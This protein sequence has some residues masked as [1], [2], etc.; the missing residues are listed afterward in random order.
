[1][2]TPSNSIFV[3]VL[4][5]TYVLWLSRRAWSILATG[6]LSSFP[7]CDVSVMLRLH[8]DTG[9]NV[10]QLTAGNRTNE[11]RNPAFLD[12][13]CEMTIFRWP[14]ATNNTFCDH[15]VWCLVANGH[16]DVKAMPLLLPALMWLA[17]IYCLQEGA[18]VTLC[19]SSPA[20]PRVASF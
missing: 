15:S 18:Q 3:S 12:V 8:E 14:S 20:L 4:C 17:R 1:M 10:L 19:F 13:G 2:L 6:A 9:K 7:F 16:F 11:E 5:F